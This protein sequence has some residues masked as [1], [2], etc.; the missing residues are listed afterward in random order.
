MVWPWHSNEATSFIWSDSTVKGFDYVPADAT[1]RL[2]IVD[3]CETE[4]TFLFGEVAD[5]YKTELV[6]VTKSRHRHKSGKYT[7]VL[8]DDDGPILSFHYRRV[9]R[10]GPLT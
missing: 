9:K 4:V 6:Y 5:V 2:T 3:Y 8:Y 10:R 1:I 7:I